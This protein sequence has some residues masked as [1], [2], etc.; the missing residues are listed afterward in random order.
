MTTVDPIVDM[1]AKAHP[2]LGGDE[3]ALYIGTL[4]YITRN[5]LWDFVKELPVDKFRDSH[6]YLDAM[7]IMVRI[8]VFTYC[9]DAFV[10]VMTIMK[11][12]AT[13]GLDSWK[14]R[15]YKYWRD[16]YL[17][18]NAMSYEDS[19][20]HYKRRRENCWKTQSWYSVPKNTT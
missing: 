3:Q 4:Q 5:E 2:F 14:S 20:E 13:H 12:I 7:R 18:V 17:A 1:I 11:D 16:E 19:S 8:G 6:P 10:W 9:D 15:R